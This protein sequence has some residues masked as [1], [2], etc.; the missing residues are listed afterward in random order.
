M[1]LLPYSGGALLISD[2]QSTRADGTKEAWDKIYFI[3]RLNCVIGFS[4]SS[5][6]SRLIAESLRNLIVNQPFNEQY[7][8]AYQQLHRTSLTNLEKEITALYI[9][10]RAGSIEAYKFT[11]DLPNILN[12]QKPVAIGNGEIAIQPQLDVDTSLLP[13]AAV[14]EFGKTLIEYASRVF[15]EVGPPSQYGF[16]IGI[17][18][19][20]GD[21]SYR[22]ESRQLVTLDRL[23]YRFP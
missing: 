1:L 11:R 22:I 8:G 10:K 7:W 12:L 4:G 17:V 5:E 14:I 18:P 13:L 20:N 2:R 23:L 16:C 6:G 3:D 9:A 21:I 15:S 19:L